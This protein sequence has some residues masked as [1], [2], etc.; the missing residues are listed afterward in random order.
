MT[1][2]FCTNCENVLPFVP[3]F[4]VDTFFCFKK[5]NKEATAT[6]LSTWTGYDADKFDIEFGVA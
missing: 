1:D 2:Y 3:E 4:R 5:A 6:W